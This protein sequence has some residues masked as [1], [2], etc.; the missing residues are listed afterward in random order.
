MAPA[1]PSSIVQ[2]HTHQSG[3]INCASPAPQSACDKPRAF[4][5]AVTHGSEFI[6]WIPLGRVPEAQL[7]ARAHT[8]PE[9]AEPP[10]AARRVLVVDDSQDGAETLAWLLRADGHEVR[11]AADGPSALAAVKAFW[12]EVV[13]MDIGLPGMD[14]YEIAARM[15]Q[16]PE[17]RSAVL[18]A[19]TGYGQEKDR[20]R[21]RQAGFDQH[22]TK[23][24]DPPTLLRVLRPSNPS[25]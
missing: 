22:L 25:G 9:P 17:M 16:A 24:V 6:V 7:P 11:T 3:A 12:P 14:G 13:F 21:S 1:Y 18:V 4:A 20:E 23:P 2:T 10:G 15:R 5:R 8:S 19:L